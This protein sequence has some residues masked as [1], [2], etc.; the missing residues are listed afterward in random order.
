MWRVAGQIIIL[1]VSDLQQGRMMGREGVLFRWARSWCRCRVGS[2][3]GVVGVVPT[4]RGLMQPSG[5][6]Y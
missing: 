2:G 4:Y 6:R 5:V 3:V 1:R